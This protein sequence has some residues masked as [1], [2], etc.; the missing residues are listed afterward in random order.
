MKTEEEIY[1]VSAD[2]KETLIYSMPARPT[3]RKP[4]ICNGP[5]QT[6]RC[7]FRGN[8]CFLKEV[9]FARV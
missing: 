8:Q 2:F 5:S 7:V 4:L 1:Q 9:I 3:Y 6:K